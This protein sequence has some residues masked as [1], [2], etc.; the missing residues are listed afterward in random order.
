M[1]DNIQ[2]QCAHRRRKEYAA[3]SGQ[4]SGDQNDGN[5]QC[6]GVSQNANG[7][8]NQASDC[9]HS[10]NDPLAVAFINDTADKGRQKHNRKHGNGGHDTHQSA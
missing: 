9:I 10:H 6:I 3:D 1:G 5:I 7:Q 4:K 2:H 8:H